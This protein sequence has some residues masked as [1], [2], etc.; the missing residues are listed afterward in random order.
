MESEYGEGNPDY[1]GYPDEPIE[2]I[3]IIGWAAYLDADLK[4]IESQP[5][6]KDELL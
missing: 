6:N 1:K 5:E 3:D 4:W 2:E